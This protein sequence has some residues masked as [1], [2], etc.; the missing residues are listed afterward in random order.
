PWSRDSYAF[1]TTLDEDWEY[2]HIGYEVGIEEGRTTKEWIAEEKKR[3]T[4]MEFK[5]LYESQFPDKSLDVMFDIEK[6]TACMRKKEEIISFEQ[7]SRDNFELLKKEGVNEVCLGCDVA[8]FGDDS[9]VIYLRSKGK[10]YSKDVL[11]HNDTQQVA[12]FINNVG[13]LV[14]KVEITPLCANIDDDGVGGGVV[15]RLKEESIWTRVNKIHNGGKPMDPEKYANRVTE[16][17]FWL[18]DNL[19]KLS[20]PYDKQ[21][22]KD[23]VT[24]KYTHK[25]TGLRILEKKSDMKKRGLKS[26]DSA[27]ALA[28]CFADY[29]EPK[30]L[31]FREVDSSGVL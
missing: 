10:V 20:L 4:P 25:G 26:P 6:L 9:T 28:Y 5:V 14:K 1:D 18:V 16:L 24:R 29:T 2:I 21:L 30:G 3:L 27:D 23:C 22:I 13:L 19:D 8:R 11:K 7:L 15:D 31:Q 17:W 12:G